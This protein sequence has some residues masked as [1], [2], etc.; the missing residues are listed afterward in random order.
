MRRYASISIL[1]IVFGLCI[2]PAFA[3]DGGPQVP[4]VPNTIAQY[5][6]SGSCNTGAVAPLPSNFT[7][8]TKH[9]SMLYIVYSQTCENMIKGNVSG[10]MPLEDIIP[11]DTS[12]QHVSGKFV[13]HNGVTI[14]EKPQLKNN[15]LY[16]TYK[17]GKTIC[18]ECVADIT[19]MQQSQQIILEPTDFNFVDKNANSTNGTWTSYNSRYMQGCDVATIANIPRL[20]NDTIQ[21]M[22]NGCKSTSFVSSSNH[23]I[24]D[25]PFSFNNPYSSLKIDSYLEKIFHNHKF[26]SSYNATNN[27]GLGPSNCITH[28]CSFTDPNKKAGY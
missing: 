15:W 16:Y 3:T 26:F 8:Q 23:V 25:T 7:F 4:S 21:Y 12:N 27:G 14:R 28:Q 20:L 11:F 6:A 17:T 18:V 2:V 1:V 24:K 19:T 22:L 5:C 10:C 9:T 13:K